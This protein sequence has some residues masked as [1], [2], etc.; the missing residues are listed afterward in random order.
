[1]RF[2]EILSK[3]FQALRIS[4]LLCFYQ[5]FINFC[6]E[7]TFERH[8]IEDENLGES[9]DPSFVKMFVIDEFELAVEFG[10]RIFIAT[11]SLLFICAFA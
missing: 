3:P 2:Y 11:F 7:S 5:S 1:M 4:L 10:S 9:R 6:L 8:A